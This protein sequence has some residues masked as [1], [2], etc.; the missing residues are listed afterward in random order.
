LS[1][2]DAVNELVR[3]LYLCQEDAKDNRSFEV[4]V[5]WICEESNFRHT[6]IPDSLLK[7]AENKA[8]QTLLSAMEFE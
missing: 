3:I 1:S 8:K 4:E 7:D 5:S 6:L 2:I